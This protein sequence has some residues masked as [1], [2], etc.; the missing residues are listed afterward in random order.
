M[1]DKLQ[2]LRR[3][4]DEVDGKLVRLLNDRTRFVLEIGAIK[5]AT[6]GEIYSPDREEAVFQRMVEQKPGPLTN[7]S[8]RAIY[9]EIMSSA[10][11]WKSH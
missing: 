8:L 6:G 2:H 5:H 3:K 7:D 4:I 11:A 1:K 10:S 9:R